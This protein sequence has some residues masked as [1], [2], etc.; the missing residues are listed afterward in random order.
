MNYKYDT[1]VWN[2]TEVFANMASAV[3][4]LCLPAR[5]GEAAINVVVTAQ[6]QNLTQ[7][8]CMDAF[9]AAGLL[10]SSIEV[11]KPKSR[12][13]ISKIFNIN[14]SEL[15]NAITLIQRETGI[16]KPPYKPTD[17]LCELC[18]RFD[19]SSRVSQRSFGHLHLL[20]EA[21]KVSNRSAY[22]ISAACLIHAYQNMEDVEA[23]NQNEILAIADTSPST[24]YRR[25]MEIKEEISNNIGKYNDINQRLKF[26]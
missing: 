17:I 5:T 20:E 25:R 10:I 13:E 3:R 24:I 16:A 6:Q 15:R 26:R 23:P 2:C 9:A 21:N 19:T 8:L 12:N 22:G 4:R 18:E 1:S 14:R 11:H 7:Q